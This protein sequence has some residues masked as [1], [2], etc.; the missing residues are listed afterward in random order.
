MVE[1][2]K[3][4]FQDF[5]DRNKEKLSSLNSM[6]SRSISLS[7]EMT[8]DRV[9]SSL[10][11][12][13][14]DELIPIE[15]LLTMKGTLKNTPVSVLKDDG[16]STN[17]ISYDFVERN[18]DKIQVHPDNFYIFHSKKQ[19]TEP[20]FGKI[21]NATVN[22]GQYSYQSNW[23]VASCNYD[24]ILGMPWH[25]T[26][27]PNTDYR[28][29]KISIQ[30]YDLPVEI[31]KPQT[32]EIT[33]IS[34]NKF[35]KS[36]K[37]GNEL[38]VFQLQVTEASSESQE[39][40]VDNPQVL[41]L[42]QKYSDVF[43]ASLPP[44]LPPER[45]VDHCIE[46]ENSTK[47]PYRPLF[48]LSPAELA[49][50]KQY[51]VEM[52]DNG[53]IRP[54]KSPYGA[55]LF[56]VKEKDNKLRAVIDYR[57]LNRVTKKNRTPLPRTDEMF[58]RLGGAK[59]FSKLDLK[60]GFNQ[61]R[62]SPDDV[63]KTAF[64]T[65]YG[66]YEYLV[67]PMGLCN[68]PATFQSLMNRIYY[69]CIDE[70]LVVYMDDLLIYSKS[71]E[72]HLKHLETIL[73]RLKE[74][75]LYV[76]PKKCEFAKQ[77]LKFL[78]LIINNRGIQVD[79]SKVDV[80]ETWPQPTNITEL[81]SFLGLLQFFRRFIKGFSKIALPLTNLTR[82]GR[83][84]DEWD[85][86]CSEAFDTLR[87]LLI[88]APILIAPQ[89][90]KPFRCH[91]DASQEAVGGTL[92]Q[93]VNGS[94]RVIGYYSHK[95][96]PA[97]CNYTANERELLGLLYFLRRHRCYL[98]GSEFEVFTDNQ[99]LKHFFSKQNLN[100]KEARWLEELSSFGIFPINLKAGK[101]H[102]LGDVLSRAPHVLKEA[103]SF[104]NVDILSFDTKFIEEHYEKD[105]F[106]GPI[107]RALDDDWPEDLKL[108][109]KL[110]RIINS[111]QRRDSL[112]FYETKLCIPRKAIPTVLQIAHDAKSA[113]HFGTAK[114]LSRLQNY[115]WK[116][117]TRDVKNYVNGCRICQQM[118]DHTGKTLTD[119]QPLQVPTR[120][121]GSLA[122]DFIVSL[123]ATKSGYDA[124]TT[125]VDR[126]TRRVHFIPSKT[127]D[128]AV[129]TARNFFHYIFP[130][131]GLPDSIVS[132]RDP[133]FTSKFWEHLME[134]LNIKL[135]RP[136]SYHPQTDGSSEIMNRMVENY[137]RCYC[138]Y[139]QDDW[140]DLLP[141]AEFAYN[142]SVS[143]SL[144]MSPFELDLGWNPKSPIDLLAT[145]KARAPQSVS[146]LKDVLKNSL[147][148]A[149][150]AYKLAKAAQAAQSAPNYKKPTYEIGD[151][152]W[153]KQSLFKDEYAKSQPKDKLTARRF[154]PFKII[155]LIGK[156]A[157][158]LELPS[159]LK[160]HSTVHVSHTRPFVKRL[161]DI[162]NPLPPPPEPV[163]KDQGAEYQVEK[164]LKHRKRGKKYRFLTLMKGDPTHEATWQPTTDFVDD[165]K[166]VNEVFLAYIKQQYLFKH[167]W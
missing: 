14:I 119:P 11:N 127:T 63:E 94:D 49:A 38:Q 19:S 69:D 89:W 146:D 2:K 13:N 45:D 78:G 73:Q 23:A 111:F 21:L 52:I 58:D 151:Q 124:I 147:S 130:L 95:L 86:K 17:I 67:M 99:V 114:T 106:L 30:G 121:W 105:Q 144:G 76:S 77:E 137:I 164:I 92:T 162:D 43:K 132:D 70:F 62:M 5:R 139:N 166:T 131:H 48:Q 138:S 16:C 82:K 156:N 91:I 9:E 118:K 6:K 145:V 81:R 72:E 51:I 15:P 41:Q 25:R 12:R 125:W 148:D 154:G 54:S 96:N 97:E 103:S 66:Q 42:I 160:I 57:G 60:T 10:G 44:G 104:N 18:K 71:L 136:T 102:V 159:H 142:S 90:N 55:P 123:P 152:V 47:P 85:H 165:D 61:I 65:K 93:L 120:R 64:N 32:V 140:D 109:D 113:G 46:V 129:D 59:Y 155:K 128:T 37:S 157:L 107:S 79:K 26:A 100:R 87:G 34:I 33:T 20:A 35:R 3:S 50:T 153:L 80:V 126:L 115:H 22:I 28:K 110:Q 24:V 143:E 135:N 74:H 101:L 36:I 68:A 117:K 149:H 1:P 112:I 158:K 134:M 53:K 27:N 116:H 141:A 161:S 7:G 98:E 163:M 29:R 31:R 39:Q 83:N 150:Y 4:A 167:L 122:T 88:K 133:K 108:K 56:F 40:K 84:L 8:P 75:K